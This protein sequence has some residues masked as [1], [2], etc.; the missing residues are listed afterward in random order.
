M[1]AV[2][3]LALTAFALAGAYIARGLR[4]AYGVLIICAY[5]AF[6]AAVL[7][8]AYPSDLGPVIGVTSTVAL[9]LVLAAWVG[10]RW[11]RRTA[12]AAR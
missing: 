8:T 1:V 9:G 2:W 3:Y 4:R 6:C 10:R 7:A 11:D 12:T 5:I